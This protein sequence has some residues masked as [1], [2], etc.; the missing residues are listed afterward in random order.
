M[1]AWELPCGSR[2]VMRFVSLAAAS[3]RE[4]V[5]ESDASGCLDSKSR[6][7]RGHGGGERMKSRI[8]IALLAAAVGAPAMAGSGSMSVQELVDLTGMKKREVQLMIGPYSNNT[9]YLTSFIRI[10]RE[11]KEAMH[12]HSLLV[13]Q[14]RDS[15]GRWVTEVRRDEQAVEGS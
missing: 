14:V 6:P 13:E 15:K 12:S 4:R 8:V 5:D 1:A 2:D 3:I 10:N 9:L 11:W 7:E